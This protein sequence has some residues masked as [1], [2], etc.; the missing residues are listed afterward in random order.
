M[1]AVGDI[2]TARGKPSLRVVGIQGDRLV[3]TLSEGF[4]ENALL[5]F[6]D[7][8]TYKAKTPAPVDENALLAS[9]SRD[10]LRDL[11]RGKRAEAAENVPLSPEQQFAKLEAEADGD[12]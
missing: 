4:A 7:A 8:A 9:M 5:S 3:V 6:A 11:D 12:G 10:W 1:T 2:L